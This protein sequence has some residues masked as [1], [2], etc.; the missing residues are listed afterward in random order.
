MPRAVRFGEYGGVEVLDVV[1]VDQPQP[2]EG[3]LLV[4]VRAAG[5]NP[6]ESKLR[7]A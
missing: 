2:G 6:F 5:I 7:A 3:Q 1:E 4:R